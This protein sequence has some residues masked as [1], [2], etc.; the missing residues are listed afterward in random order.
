MKA[1]STL[2]LCAVALGLAAAEL[3]PDSAY[4]T[5]QN[6]QLHTNGERIR[7]WCVIGGFP[8]FANIQPGDAPDVRTA[9]RDH[10]YRDADALVRRFIDLGFNGMRLWEKPGADYVKGDGSRDDVLDYFVSRAKAAGMRIWVPAVSVAPVRATDV[11]LVDEPATADAW[12]KAVEQNQPDTWIARVWD[13]RLE[14]AQRQILTQRTRRMNHHTGLPWGDDPVFAIWEL[15]NEEW[16]MMKMVGGVWQRLPAFFQDSLRARWH[17]FLREKYKDESRLRAAWG[18]LLPDESLRAG[19]VRLGPLAGGTPLVTAGMDDQARRQVEA[20]FL[21]KAP[22]LSRS[23]VTRARGE[24]VLEF[25][26]G[27]QLAHKKRLQAH[28]KTLGKSARLGP[29]VF[30][31][32]IGYE[33]QSQFMHQH[34][35]AVAHDAYINGFTGDRTHPRFPFYSGLEEP[36]RIAQDVPWL[37]HNRVEGKPYLC[38]ETQ[39]MQPAK[40]R[41]E[42]PYRLLALAAIQD[43]DAICWHYWG[44]VPDIT[45]SPKPFDRTM[46]VTGSGHPQG[47]HFTY[48][49]VQNAAMR[50]AAHAFRTGAL[51]PALNPTKFIYGRRSLYDPASMDY[52][53]SYGSLGL[54]MLPTTYRHGVRIWIDPTREDD[55]AIGPTANAYANAVPNRISPH[56]QIVFDVGRGG[57]TFDSPSFLGFTGF[58]GRFGERMRFRSGVSL[59]DV[60]IDLPPG[61][62]YSDGLKT[63]RYLAFGIAAE[64]GLPLAKTR[65]ATLFLVSTSFNTGLK[66]LMNERGISQGG[67]WPVLHARVSGTVSAPALAGMRYRFLDWHLQPLA[68]GTVPAGGSLRIPSDRPIWIVELTRGP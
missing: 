14:A 23:S 2:A 32:G 68:Q 4:V 12:R 41:A 5:V 67:D 40:Y 51:K 49:A 25:F 58:F 28:L 36:P 50:A 55:A 54:R 43:W 61:M 66:M 6:G 31:T 29:T 21:G 44:S 56:D 63:D 53:M 42:Y 47:Y 11:G 8:N 19:T 27:L 24:D 39:I 35:D 15:T 37:E 22:E 17:D 57:L 9:R 30:D 7:L 26:V 1:S 45:T 13:P 3:P 16:W 34:A 20:A 65:R 46:D 64:D 10:A 62:P 38:Y 18:F 48:D 33:I 52:G 60:A 59:S